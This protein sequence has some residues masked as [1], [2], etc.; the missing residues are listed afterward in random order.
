MT[1][2]VRPAR[3]SDTPAILAMLGTLANAH[4]GW[5][6]ARFSTGPQTEPAY[7]AWLAQARAG[8][9]VLALVAETDAGVVGYMIAE[10]LPGEPKYWSTPCVYVHDIYL[11]PAARGLGLAEALLNQARAWA[12]RLGV[13]QVRALVSASNP[14]GQSFFTRSGFRVGA[15]EMTISTNPNPSASDHGDPS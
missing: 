10:S 11:D 6:P 7:R 2:T 5:D 9:P 15:V 1:P 13:P 14:A 12:D 8:G 3:E 4:T